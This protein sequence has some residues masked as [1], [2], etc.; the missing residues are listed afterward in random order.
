M[1]AADIMKIGFLTSEYPHH[2]TGSAGGIG[3]S[4]KNLA[5]ALVES[6]HD[7]HILVYN[8]SLD[9]TFYADAI[10]VHQI[11]NIKLKG[12]S[13]YL[14]RKKIESYINRL[15]RE[16][17]IDILEAPDW[18]GI[19]SFIQPK[20]CPVVIR[21]HGSD[22]YFCNLEKRHLKKINYWHERRALKKADA[23]ISVSQFTAD[24][25]NEFFYLSID[26]EIIPN[27]INTHYFRPLEKKDNASKQILYLGTLIRK[28]GLLDLAHIFNRVIKA[29]PKAELILV[30]GDAQDVSTGKSSTW[31]V[32]KDIFS[33]QA[34]KSVTY[35]GKVPYE[36]V[37]GTIQKAD[38]CV[39]PS[40][41]EALPVS[42]LEAMA[43]QKAIVA[44]NIGWG[45]EVIIHEDSGLLA[46]PSN[47]QQFAG[48]ILK[49]LSDPQYKRQI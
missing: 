12:L 48:Y 22:T 49:L 6:G 28:K 31:E 34:S 29:E 42:W 41:A 20:K 2:Q 27:G 19:T 5:E 8:Q 17:R 9:H 1:N 11:K 25:T 15:Y 39:F 37:Q 46:H 32:M 4:I 45:K 24:K 13:W 26:F 30:G 16:K 23:H 21:L 40:Y 44:S 3:T 38:I 35:L 7:V 14:T 47:Y 33:K 18:T 10:K 43:M 36:K